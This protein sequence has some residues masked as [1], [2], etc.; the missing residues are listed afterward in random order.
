MLKAYFKLAKQFI[1]Y[2]ARAAAGRSH[3]FSA[4]EEEKGTHRPQDVIELSAEH[5]KTWHYIRRL[6]RR[7]TAGDESEEN[8]LKDELVKMWMLLISHNTGARRYRSP[9]LSP[10]KSS[11]DIVW[12]HDRDQRIVTT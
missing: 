9:L 10:A 2:L 11:R 1:I 12:H 8:G 7:K 4:N 3:H 6:A 5:P